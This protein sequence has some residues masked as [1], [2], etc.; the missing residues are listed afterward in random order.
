[1][2]A[3]ATQA[4]IAR[5]EASLAELKALV[6]PVLSLAVRQRSRTEQARKSGVSVRTLQRREKRL[7]ARL[8][9]GGIR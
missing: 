1:V 6:A 5:L 3:P 7:A 4:D 9:V 8:A 2:S